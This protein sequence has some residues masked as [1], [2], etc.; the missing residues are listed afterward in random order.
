MAKAKSSTCPLCIGKANDEEDTVSWIKCDIC[1]QWVHTKCGAVAESEIGKLA[2]FHC[3]ECLKE[4]GPSQMKRQLKRVRV[5]IDYVA[6]DQGEVFAVDK[7]AHPH[8]PSFNSFEPEIDRNNKQ[9]FVDILDPESLTKQFVLATGLTRPVLV[10]N[11]DDGDCGMELPCTRS[12][13]SVAYI[14][15]KTG[16]DENVEVMDVLS[17]QSESPGWSLKQWKTYF[18]TPVEDRDRIRNVI[19][20]E[21]SHVAKLGQNFVRPAMVR[22]LDL[23]DKVWRDVDGNDQ[24]R[25]KVTVY[26]LMSVAGSYTDFHIDFSGTPVY[27]TVCLGLKT[28][29]M[30]PP[31]DE[32]LQLYTSWCQEPQQN[33]TW[34][35]DYTKRIG[36][37][38]IKPQNGFKINLHQGD[39][40]IIPSGWIH[41]VYTPDDAVIIG[42]NYLTLRDIPMHLKVYN[43]EK[44]TN[45][46]SRYRFP[47]F[48]K[49]MWLASWYYMN[50][51]DEFFG[52][53][54]ADIKQESGTD[55]ICEQD[56]ASVRAGRAVL[57]SLITHL[58]EHYETSKTKPVAKKS[59]PTS[60]IGRNVTEYI[61]KLEKWA[62]SM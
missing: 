62:L 25:P 47:M 29:L 6:L 8:V 51:Q 41:S 59:I 5:K 49:V 3:P 57:T 61:E 30:Y 39:L 17:Q 44:S 13:I 9:T 12:D 32:N 42:G 26:C 52:D 46:P 28:F 50:N 55:C 40:F 11:V 16:E 22:Q 38:K 56:S 53:I 37:K 58:K 35:G 18:Y 20:L 45:V 23:V 33:F 2:A 10:A 24:K 34:F 31:T 27:Y 4:H 21:V 48:N 36:G 7:S 60:L 54:G 19:S 15:E 14:A 1:R 43:I